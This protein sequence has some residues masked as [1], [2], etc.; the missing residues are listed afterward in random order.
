MNIN[1]ILTWLGGDPNQGDTVEYD[2]YLGKSTPPPLVEENIKQSAYAPGT[3]DLET[4]YYWKI[5]AEDDN[6]LTAN[7]PIWSFTTQSEPNDPPEAPE[8]Y[9]PPSGP[10]N[11]QLTWAFSSFDP[12]GHDVKYIINWGDGDTHETGY[13]QESKVVDASH[14]YSELGDYTIIIKAE[15]DRGLQGPE[16]SFDVTITRSKNANQR[17]LI[18]LFERFPLLERLMNL[19][20]FY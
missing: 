14:S 8:I 7:G 19:F 17:L 2:V 13:Y 9:G 20:N 16:S 3:L 1:K 6:G 10:P 5:N 12:D 4:K 11:R 15:D 18:L